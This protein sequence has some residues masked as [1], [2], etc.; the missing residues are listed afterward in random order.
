V[1]AG[2]YTPRQVNELLGAGEVQLIDVRER[3][4]HDAGR[5][6]GSRLIELAD[7][8]VA[9]VSIDRE[10]P[11]IVYCRSG[12]RSAIATDALRGAGFDAHNMTGGLLAWDARAAAGA[13]GRPRGRALRVRRGI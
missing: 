1:D 5:I 9:A 13:G 2:D 4:E 10:R 8:P 6:S 11:V 7:L 3:S 12:A